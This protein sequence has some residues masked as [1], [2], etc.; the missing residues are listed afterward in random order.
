MSREEC[1]DHR[2]RI[3]FEVEVILQGYWQVELAPQMKA[4]VLADWA[5]E[6]EDWELEQVR[7]ALREWRRENPRR[8]PNAGD[9]LAILK[10]E[11]GKAEMAR[12]EVQ[13]RQQPVEAREPISAERAAELCA[14]FGFSPKRIEPLKNQAT[15]EEVEAMT[16]GINIEAA[17]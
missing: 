10:A 17:E 13:R 6:L 15:P 11:R 12:L 2:A 7:W 1:A 5:D 14:A 9:V 4:A 16:A 8:K 3:A